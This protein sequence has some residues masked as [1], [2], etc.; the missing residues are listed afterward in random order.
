MSSG[1]VTDEAHF[2]CL[3]LSQDG[4]HW[5][6][7]GLGQLARLRVP[8][9][10]FGG[11]RSLLSADIHEQWAWWFVESLADPRYYARRG[12][13]YP[14][15]FEDVNRV[16]QAR[17]HHL[18]KQEMKGVAST[19]ARIVSQLVKRLRE[20]TRRRRLS[21]GERVRLLDFA[22]ANPRCWICGSEF[23]EAAVDNFRAQG[24]RQIPAPALLDVLKPR[25]PVSPG[26]GY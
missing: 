10:L 4:S 7:D 25:G 21:P 9:V 15:I 13:R 20:G 3:A 11:R 6:Q 26:F 12:A 19:A 16:V 17:F 5:T 23:M 2:L 14:Q 1:S 8:E 22:G 18:G 24:G